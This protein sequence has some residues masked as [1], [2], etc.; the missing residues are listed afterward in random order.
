MLDAGVQEICKSIL[1]YAKWENFSKVK[2]KARRIMFVSRHNVADQIPD[3]R[4]IVT[5]GSGSDKEMDDIFVTRYA[6]YL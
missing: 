5:I 4:K 1:G 6:C 2:E 3:I